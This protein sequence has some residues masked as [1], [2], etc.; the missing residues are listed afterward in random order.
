MLQ[1]SL[2]YKITLPDGSSKVV[3]PDSSEPDFLA[4]LVRI[5]SDVSWDSSDSQIAA[6]DGSLIGDMF[7]GTRTIVLDLLLAEHDQITRADKLEWLQRINGILR[8]T[9]GITLSWREA[10]GFEKEVANLR[11]T[12]YVAIGDAWPKQVQVVLRTG[13]P[14]ILSSEIHTREIADETGTLSLFNAGNAPAYPRF[15]VYG[16]CDDFSITNSNTSDALVFQTAVADGDYI[17]IDARRRTVLL[18]GGQNAYGGIDF[19]T[20]EFFSLPPLSADLPIVFATSG[21]GANTK[22]VARWQSAWE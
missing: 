9:T 18:N 10:T 20:T 15:F 19:S 11:P 12:S 7:R 5:T 16:P 17:E 8:N 22:L 13:N 2:P 3:G 14:F 4:H 21:G 6:G 1:T